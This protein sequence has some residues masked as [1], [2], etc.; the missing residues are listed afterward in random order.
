MRWIQDIL[1]ALRSLAHGVRLPSEK[2]DY[3]NVDSVADKTEMVWDN[4]AV[5]T[6]LDIFLLLQLMFLST[7]TLSTSISLS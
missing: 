7:V 1:E 5:K 6:S 3:E 2:V 4:V